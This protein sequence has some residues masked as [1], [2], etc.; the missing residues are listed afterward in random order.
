MFKP[1]D[2][3]ATQFNRYSPITVCEKAAKRYLPKKRYRFSMKFPSPFLV[4][5]ISMNARKGPMHIR[6]GHSHNGAL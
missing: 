6:D 4:R 5:K 3:I 1:I 2:E